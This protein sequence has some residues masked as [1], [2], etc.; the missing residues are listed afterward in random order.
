MTQYLIELDNK[1][2]ELMGLS[3]EWLQIS[4]ESD[5]INFFKGKLDSY[6]TVKRL[7]KKLKNNEGID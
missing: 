5:H 6:S 3:R 1:I 4:T 7:I 2:N